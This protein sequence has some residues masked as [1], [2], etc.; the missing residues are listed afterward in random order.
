MASF[1]RLDKLLAEDPDALQKIEERVKELQSN[2]KAYSNTIK[3]RMLSGVSVSAEA[4]K[5]AACLTCTPALFHP[6]W[7]ALW[8]CRSS[9]KN[10][11]RNHGVDYDLEQTIFFSCVSRLIKPSSKTC[12]LASSELV[13]HGFFRD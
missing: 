13:S 10:F 9:F 5:R 4:T 11:R 12:K 1:G 7:E 8:N 2:S 6:V 3:E